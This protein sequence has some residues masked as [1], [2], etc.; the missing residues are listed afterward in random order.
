MAHSEETI[1]G[2]T[3]GD[4]ERLASTRTQ[5]ESDGAGPPTEELPA[6]IDR[7]AVRERVG[8][9]GMGVVYRAHDPKLGRDV[10]I[11]VVRGDLPQADP[12]RLRR[13]AQALAAL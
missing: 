10:A 8:A 13:E 1:D 3:R 4:D 9:G 6:R 11:K 5:A 12:I 2:E 7:F